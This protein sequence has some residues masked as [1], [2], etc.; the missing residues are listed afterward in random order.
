MRY[1]EE[2]QR[3]A[4]VINLRALEAIDT[5]VDHG[6]VRS[7]KTLCREL[8]IEQKVLYRIR[9]EPERYRMPLWVLHTLSSRFA[10]RAE[11]LLLG[12]GKMK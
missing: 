9:K 4:A 10:I 5:L 6:A 12:R 3:E 2:Q 11:W 8:G 7:R 1:P